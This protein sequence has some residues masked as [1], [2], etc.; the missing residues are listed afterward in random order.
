MRALLVAILT[1]FLAIQADAQ[2]V[3]LRASLKVP[4]ITVRHSE[5]LPFRIAIALNDSAA[6][7]S[8]KPPY[9]SVV[10]IVEKDG[11]I[12]VPAIHQSATSNMMVLDHKQ[13]RGLV[14]YG[15][16]RVVTN[17][18]FPSFVVSENDKKALPFF[19]PTQPAA[20]DAHELI[21]PTRRGNAFLYY[22]PREYDDGMKLIEVGIKEFSTDGDLL[23]EWT[24]SRARKFNAEKA[25][26][27]FHD[28]LH[29]NSIS[30]FDKYIVISVRDTSEVW[31]IDRDR[32]EIAHSIGLADGWTFKGDPRNGFRYQ[33][34]A[35]IDAGGVLTLFDNSGSYDAPFTVEGSRAVRF[36][37]SLATK[38]ATLIE[39][40]PI[41]GAVKERSRQGSATFF[42]NGDRLIGWGV[43]EPASC[44]GVTEQPLVY[45]VYRDA[46][47]IAE[48]QADCGWYSYRALPIFD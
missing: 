10:M 25:K 44:Q 28:Y 21:S 12:T 29:V 32:K 39:S 42:E 23:W 11:R 5:T 14:A 19:V 22:V 17:N 37:I 7:I 48:M 47:V 1:V 13:V 6:A 34:H 26:A 9:S 8:G 27:H 45:S 33:H 41:Y 4:K 46:K 20:L 30:E 40:I 35:H 15:L 31:L 2:E 36:R 24:S 38:S 43:A 16:S 18:L 3:D